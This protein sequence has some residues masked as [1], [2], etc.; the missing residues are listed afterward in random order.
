[1][2][3]SPPNAAT[4]A[5]VGAHGRHS[6]GDY[7]EYHHKEETVHTALLAPPLPVMTPSEG[8]LSPTSTF[9]HATSSAL[10]SPDSLTHYAYGSYFPAHAGAGPGFSQGDPT[11]YA[12]LGGGAGGADPFADNASGSSG[13]TTDLPN[14]AP[15]AHAFGLGP[16]DPDYLFVDHP[17]AGVYPWLAYSRRNT[18]TSGRT[19]SVVYQTGG[20][21][22]STPGV[23]GAPQYPRVPFPRQWTDESGTTMYF[24]PTG[25]EIPRRM[26]SQ[27]NYAEWFGHSSGAAAAGAAGAAPPVPITALPPPPPA[28]RSASSS[29]SALPTIPERGDGLLP[30][31]ATDGVT[32]S[33]VRDEGDYTKARK[34]TVCLHSIPVPSVF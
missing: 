6:S 14:N 13:T 12:L 30:Q 2:A 32:P 20:S 27:A 23:M 26:A 24:T 1:M 19:G 17:G 10:V 31:P 4:Y 11:R 25:E 21:G 28:A 7:G 9:D 8:M 16:G 29:G 22:P 5:G 15:Y 18:S 3:F 34:L 33:S